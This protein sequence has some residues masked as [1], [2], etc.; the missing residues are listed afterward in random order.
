MGLLGSDPIR[1]Q[2]ELY[3]FNSVIE[4]TLGVSDRM[5]RKC[6]L[7]KG[8]EQHQSKSTY[9]LPCTHQ[10]QGPSDSPDYIHTCNRLL[11]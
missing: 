1:S 10:W 5:L 4:L 2:G 8:P 7:L 3:Y 11:S 6:L 9:L